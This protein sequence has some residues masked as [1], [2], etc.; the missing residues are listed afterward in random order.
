MG[1]GGVDVVA[2]A[3][4]VRSDRPRC[5]TCHKGCVL[6]RCPRRPPTTPGAREFNP[7]RCRIDLGQ[8]LPIVRQDQT[9][10]Y[11]GTAGATHSH[12]VSGW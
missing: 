3:D 11:F 9:Q 4:Y 12:T 10:E 7:P 8:S 6:V 2:V 5:D 1:R